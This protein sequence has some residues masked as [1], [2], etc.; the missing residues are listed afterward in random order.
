MASRYSPSLQTK[1]GSRAIGCGLKQRQRHGQISVYSKQ[2]AVHSA[3]GKKVQEASKNMAHGNASHAHQLVEWNE[4]KSTRGCWTH[5]NAGE[6]GWSAAAPD[7]LTTVTC[8]PASTRANIGKA[9]ERAQESVA[10]DITRERERERER[11]SWGQSTVPT[12][13]FQPFFSENVPFRC[14][15]GRG[16]LWAHAPQFSG[17]VLRRFVSLCNHTAHSI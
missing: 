6:I 12:R 3:V 10:K 17:S 15:T 13:M 8:L 16:H 4:H 7:V 9:S 11:E 1:M 2:Y 14:G 5:G